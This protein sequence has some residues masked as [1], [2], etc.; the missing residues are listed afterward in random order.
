MRKSLS[1]ISVWVATF[2][3]LLSTIVMHHHHYE[4]ACIVVSHCD[5]DAYDGFGA[6]E[7]AG[8]HSHQEQ[9]SGCCRVHQMHRFITNASVAKDI[10]RHIFG[11]SMSLAAMLPDARLLPLSC[12][13]VAVRWRHMAEPVATGAPS[14][15]LRRGPPHVLCIM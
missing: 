13:S 7:E 6:T 10:R 11:G 4:S 9:D 15:M 8:G 2:I 12:G 5:T 1:L 14:C 3:M